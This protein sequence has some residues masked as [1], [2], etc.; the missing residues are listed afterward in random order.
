MQTA[1]LAW[2]IQL[3]HEGWDSVGQKKPLRKEEVKETKTMKNHGRKRRK[4]GFSVW[5]A[6][7]ETW[8]PPL[9]C[10]LAS[11]GERIDWR[12][13]NGDSATARRAQTETRT[14][15]VGF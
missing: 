12:P 1:S 3:T 14:T 10:Q 9:A 5:P 11:A 13:K 4:I 2:H 6:G 8:L 15:N 7:P